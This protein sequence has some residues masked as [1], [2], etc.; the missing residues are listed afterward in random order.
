MT[1]HCIFT[2]RFLLHFCVISKWFL[3][4]RDT[5]HFSNVTKT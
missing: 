1:C 5:F 2:S 3:Y 4:F